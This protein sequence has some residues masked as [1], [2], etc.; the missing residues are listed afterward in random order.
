MIDT[1]KS[2]EAEQEI[3]GL[4]QHRPSHTPEA[5][6]DGLEERASEDSESVAAVN[7]AE[8]LLA[9][10][11]LSG[12][13]LISILIGGVALSL[14]IVLWHLATEYN[15]N[16]FINFENTPSPG[17]VGNAFVTHFQDGEFYIHILVSIRRILIAYGLAGVLGIFHR[18]VGRA[19]QARARRRLALH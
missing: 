1:K 18:V 10:F 7:L 19:L 11:R 15:F 9:Q 13:T 6:K 14:G 12:A 3:A 17:Q 8:P 5:V 2:H 4:D 16:Y